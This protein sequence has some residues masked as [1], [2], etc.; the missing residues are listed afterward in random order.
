MEGMGKA[1]MEEGDRDMGKSQTV[2]GS[3]GGWG[4]EEHGRAV[5]KE[6]DG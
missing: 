2:E 5:K 3:I 1:M 6:G 4:E